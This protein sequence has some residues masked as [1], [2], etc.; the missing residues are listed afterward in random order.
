MTELIV[1]FAAAA[2]GGLLASLLKQPIILGYL[3]AGIIVGPFELGL[4]KDYAEVETIAELGVTF[5]LFTIGVE[6]SFAELNKVKKISLGGGGLQILL[7]ISLT[8]LVAVIAGWVTSI[9]Q[10]IFL[11]ELISLSST[12]VVLKALK[13]WRSPYLIQSASDCA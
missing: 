11:G 10:G 9:P 3:L 8:A 1:I 4:I 7:T 13:E 12:A 5:L 2:I 6:F